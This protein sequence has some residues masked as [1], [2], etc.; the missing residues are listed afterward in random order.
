VTLREQ[1]KQIV[2]RQIAETQGGPSSK[3][4]LGVVAAVNADGTVLI[5]INGVNY[6]AGALY[7]LVQGQQ[8]IAVFGDG[9]K[10]SAVPTGQNTPPT[11]VIPPPF[12]SG[13]GGI[14]FLTNNYDTAKVP[15]STFQKQILLEDSITKNVF[16]LSPVLPGSNLLPFLTNSHVSGLYPPASFSPNGKFLAVLSSNSST[17]PTAVTVFVYNLGSKQ[18][19]GTSI[20]PTLFSI[21]PT[22]IAKGSN[23]IPANP[24]SGN[25]AQVSDLVVDDTGTA[26]WMAVTFGSHDT[27]DVHYVYKLIPDPNNLTPTPI[28]LLTTTPPPLSDLSAQFG[29][30]KFWKA[31]TL[32][33]AGWHQPS[34]GNFSQAI[35]VLGTYSVL[36]QSPLVSSGKNYFYY[37]AETDTWRAAPFDL[38]GSLLEDGCWV[39]AKGAPDGPIV[40]LSMPS[41]TNGSFRAFEAEGPIFNSSGDSAAN[42]DDLNLF[43]LVDTTI[44]GSPVFRVARVAGSPV[45]GPISLSSTLVKVAPGSADVNALTFT[46]FAPAGSTDVPSYKFQ[47]FKA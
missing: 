39:Q 27:T 42:K 37:V 12:F 1:I 4:Q 16:V 33:V 8:C 14:R 36:A 41:V 46:N 43:L 31:S 15:G 6:T 25:G 18:F 9:G 19:S 44:P 47:R 10:I 21:A 22:L 34:V 13:A 23:S 38:T 32:S 30:A 40:A 5:S 24:E 26:Y 45:A 11:E 2:R 7:P 35:F 20:A 29:P 28:L 3:Y 17:A